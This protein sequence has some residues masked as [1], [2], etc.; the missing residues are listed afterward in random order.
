MNRLGG[1][2]I[3]FDSFQI[4][5]KKK[6]TIHSTTVVSLSRYDRDNE[7]DASKIN[8][9]GSNQDDGGDAVNLCFSWLYC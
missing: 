9:E 2:L 6:D 3:Y 1:N 8:G 4:K 5:K 7:G